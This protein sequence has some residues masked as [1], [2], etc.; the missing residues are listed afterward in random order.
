MTQIPDIRISDYT[1]ELPEEKIAVYPL[2][3]REQ[4]RLL[5]WKGG[6]ITETLFADAGRMV[7]ENSL[8]V[9]NNTRVIHARLIFHTPAGARVE[10]FCLEPHHP[11]DYQLSFQSTATVEWKCLVGNARKWKQ[12][13]LALTVPIG[14]LSVTLQAEMTERLGNAFCIHFSWDA[15]ITFASLIEAAGNMPIPPY[16]NRP[17]ETIDDDRYQ[18]TYARIDGSVAAPTAGLHFTP[19]VME[20]LRNNHISFAELT[21]HVGAGT[22][23]PVKS[24][25]VADHD[26]HTETVYV[27]KAFLRTMLNHDG[28]VIAV[29]TTSVR[30]LESLYWLGAGWEESSAKATN[31]S[32]DENQEN[33]SVED[34]WHVEQWQPYT[35]H[36]DLSPVKALT[37]LLNWMENH[38]TD[39]LSFTTSIIIIPGYRFRMISGMFTNFHQPNS[40]LLLLVAAFLGHDWKKVYDYALHH[41]FRFLSYGDANLYLKS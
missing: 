24:E 18:T 32:S 5:L 23:Q 30:S 38:H 19:R 12:G 33:P 10:I 11:A 14:D 36:T 9:F 16:L 1:Y 41:N 2:S 20:K 4:S 28:Q 34:P 26:M 7:P 21:L 13:T 15:Q 22:F 31:G 25:R 40:T 35:H 37:N 6:H 29:G 17:A 8:L 27:T 3:E 39:Q